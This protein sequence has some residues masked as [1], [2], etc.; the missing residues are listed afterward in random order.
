M[1]PTRPGARRCPA[2]RGLTRHQDEQAWI[3]EPGRMQ[4]PPSARGESSKVWLQVRERQQLFAQFLLPA[5]Y[6]T[7]R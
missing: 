3:S 5:W 1:S 4:S 6:M 2:N 7:G